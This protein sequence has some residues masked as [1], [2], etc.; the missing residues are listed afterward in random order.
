[1]S[2]QMGGSVLLERALAAWGE[3]RKHTYDL[4]D[5]LTDEQPLES[6][7]RPLFNSFGKQLQEL[8]VIQKAYANAIRT[9]HVDYSEMAFEFDNDM[10]ISKTKL[11]EFLEEMDTEFVDV[12]RGS[13]PYKEIDWGLPSNPILLEHV[14][15]LLQHEVLHHGQLAAYC[16]LLNIDLPTSWIEA[17]AFPP[18]DS[19]IVRQ[20]LQNR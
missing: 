6:F 11:R 8:G 15:W 12:V 18:K 19:K 20:W 17:W 2:D 3:T 16:Y 14:Y 7:P 10:I 4:L 9:G 5:V 13:D 1:M